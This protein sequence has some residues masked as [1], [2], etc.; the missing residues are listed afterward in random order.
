MNNV[1]KAADETDPE[2]PTL[3]GEVPPGPQ[4]RP[5][6]RKPSEIR[7][8]LENE[9][10]RGVLKPGEAL[11]ERAL[12]LRFG[13]S[14][15]PIREVLPQLAASGLITIVPNVGAHVSHLSVGEVRALLEFITEGEA[16]C[17]KLA[18]RR[19]DAE[20][21]RALDAALEDC[22]CAAVA[23]EGYSKANVRFHEAIYEGSR[24]PYL[25]M[26]I[27]SARS[28][29]QRYRI[30]D[31]QLQSHID[32]SLEQ[33]RQIVEAIKAGDELRAAQLMERHLPSGGAGFSEFL[34]K[35]PASLLS[36][37]PS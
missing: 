7:E 11:D 29:L 13:V 9:I 37:N 2:I 8:V 32:Q 31:L 25:A 16:L 15:T 33:H 19:I 36:Q 14:R 28:K 17:A 23:A 10:Q 3:S 18:A 24:N 34:A 21:A 22:G 5:R 1:Q 4:E 6:P 12:A 35:L 27:R 26:Q 30:K 20:S